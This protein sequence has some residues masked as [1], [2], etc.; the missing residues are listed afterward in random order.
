MDGIISYSTDKGLTGTY[1][2]YWGIGY[3]G[4]E[5][6]ILLIQSW[7]LRC[8]PT[9]FFAFNK[10]SYTG[11]WLRQDA[12]SAKNFSSNIIITYICKHLY[13]CHILLT[14]LEIG[15][16]AQFFGHIVK[17]KLGHMIWMCFDFI[18][19]SKKNLL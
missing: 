2:I 3:S 10:E 4:V 11:R 6:K 16:T 17:F 1:H 12:F 15:I 18:E 5:R 19:K 7:V 8:M 14:Q 9:C 13:N